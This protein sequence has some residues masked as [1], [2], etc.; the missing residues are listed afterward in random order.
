LGRYVA[1]D[2]VSLQ[3][4]QG[5]LLTILGPSGSGKTTLLKVV[6]GFE[7]PD[8]A[9]VRSAGRRHPLPPAGA[10]SAW[11]SRTTRCSRI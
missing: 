3:V 1:L 2:H 5:E 4:A 10:T 6:A 8:A 11:C 9:D 7:T